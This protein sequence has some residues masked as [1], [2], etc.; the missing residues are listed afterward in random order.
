MSEILDQ[1]WLTHQQPGGNHAAALADVQIDFDAGQQLQLELLA[2]WQNA[3]ETVGGWKIGMTSGASRNALGA[4]LRP[5]GFILNSRIIQSGD[6]LPVASLFTGQIEN[7]LCFRMQHDLGAGATR[8]DAVA[9]TGALLPA[10]EINQ[11]RLG[12]SASPG[13][14]VADDLSNWGIVVG[15]PAPVHDELTMLNV[16]LHDANGVIE[17]VASPGH[18]DDHFESLATLA[19]RLAEFGQRLQAGQYVITGAYG[20]TPF[21]PGT[22]TGQ[23]DCGIGDVTINLV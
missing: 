7:E 14:R 15:A 22:Y 21:A 11:K 4:G 20:K 1:L 16:E 12:G 3:G 13:L 17:S 23:F 9:A 5:F 10:F 2:R 8:A 19:R 18:I 6:S